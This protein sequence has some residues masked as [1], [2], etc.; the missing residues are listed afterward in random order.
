MKIFIDHH[1]VKCLGIVGDSFITKYA[2]ECKFCLI[3]NVFFPIESSIWV[4]F[5]EKIVLENQN[6]FSQ[7]N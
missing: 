2:V 7:F 5:Y 1:K 4:D 6:C 3:R